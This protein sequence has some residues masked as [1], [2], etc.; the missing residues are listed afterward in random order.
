MLDFFN[1][2]IALVGI[3][4]FIAMFSGISMGWYLAA[5]NHYVPVKS[6]KK[7]VITN[8]V[9]SVSFIFP[10]AFERTLTGSPTLH[11][12]QWVAMWALLVT[13]MMAADLSNYII[14]MVRRK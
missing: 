11:P 5:L 6:L 10:I 9:G 7:S 2:L 8:I 1:D 3:S 14:C 4:G 12:T 13:F